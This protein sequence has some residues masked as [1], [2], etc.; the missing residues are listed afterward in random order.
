MCPENILWDVQFISEVRILG[1]V[2]TFKWTIKMV[3]VV[4]W[5]SKMDAQSVAVVSISSPHT[6]E[7][8]HCMISLKGLIKDTEYDSDG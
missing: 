5:N 3:L 2:V 1:S 6:H 7:T 4:G 8:G